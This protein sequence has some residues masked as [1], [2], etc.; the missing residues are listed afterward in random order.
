MKVALILLSLLSFPTLAWSKVGKLDC[1]SPS[2]HITI[3]EEFALNSGYKV[4]IAKVSVMGVSR[5][6]FDV[7]FANQKQVPATL[8]TAAL[9]GFTVALTLP[10]R[11]ELTFTPE[12]ESIVGHVVL[13]GGAPEPVTCLATHQ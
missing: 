8:F 3:L 1:K 7:L 2:S 12:E 10:A 6:G 11:T 13:N 5:S 4:V 9:P